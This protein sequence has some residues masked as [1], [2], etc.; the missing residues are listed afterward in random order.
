MCM[1]ADAPGRTQFWRTPPLHQRPSDSP[2]WVR[3]DT[4]W[5]YTSDRRKQFLGGSSAKERPM[6]SDRRGFLKSGAT[7]AGGLTLGR[8]APAIGQTQGI[9]Q[10]PGS[11]QT[12]GPE[13]FIKAGKELI[14]YG[15][16]SR[17]VTSVRM[18]HPPEGRPSPD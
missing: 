2:D 1:A 5:D 16:R 6:K 15:G 4:R 11:G 9:G 14:A 18:A 17:F 3:L 12:P 13:K 7:L 8:V 10:T